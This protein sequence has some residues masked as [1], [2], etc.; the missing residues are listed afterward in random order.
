MSNQ[1]TYKHG[2]WNVI[3]DI[4]GFKK[5][6]S[7]VRLRWD[8]LYVC[9]EDW[10]TRHPQEFLRTPKDDQS[11]PWTRPEPTDRFADAICTGC[12]RSAIAG[13]AVVGCAI[14]GLDVYTDCEVPTGTFDGSL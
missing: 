9:K 8:G 5:K 13:K 2:D 1:N 11:V 7:E 14:A 3:C 4:C 6:A 12:G 10:E